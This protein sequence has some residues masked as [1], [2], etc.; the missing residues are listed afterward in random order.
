MSRKQELDRLAKRLKKNIAKSIAAG[1]HGIRSFDEA[2][3]LVEMGRQP[4]KLRSVL[5][6]FAGDDPKP[7]YTQIYQ[8]FCGGIQ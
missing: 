2:L 8:R 1:G 5:E 3:M 7:T 6:T 4:E